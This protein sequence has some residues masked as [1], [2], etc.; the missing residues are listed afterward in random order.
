MN[1]CVHRGTVCNSPRWKITE[2]AFISHRI[3]KNTEA[4]K[5]LTEQE[6]QAMLRGGQCGQCEAVCEESGEKIRHL[7]VSVHRSH[8]N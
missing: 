2:T 3:R 1:E 4:L 7:L 5:V 8:G 6:L